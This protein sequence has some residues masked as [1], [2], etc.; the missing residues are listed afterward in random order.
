L[1]EALET[2]ELFSIDGFD[3]LIRGTRHRSRN[4]IIGAES[5][6]NE[7]NRVGIVF[8]NSMSPTRAANG[9]SAV[10]FADSFAE[11]G[12][13]SFRVDLPGF[14]DADGDPSAELHAYINRGG[15]A[16]VAS[17]VISD[18]VRRFHLPGVVIVGHCAGTVSA[19]FTAGA[20]RDCKGL[21][22]MAPYF[23]LPQVAKSQSQQPTHLLPDEHDLP[24]NANLPLLCCLQALSSRGIPIL[25]LNKPERK[26]AEMKAR[27]RTFD[28]LEYVVKLAA[29][30]NRVDLRLAEGSDHSFSNRA[31][32]AAVR[33]HTE[34]WLEANF[35]LADGVGSKVPALH[36][37][38]DPAD[39]IV[40][41]AGGI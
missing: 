23:Y 40:G 29:S 41:I 14:G 37:E 36:Q 32:R 19:I 18:L 3:G 28:Y 34:S 15:Y 25:I 33:H 39:L 6:V 10:Y 38:S 26:S 12:Y 16:P 13:P 8:V 1:K 7:Q 9:D 4:E 20:S 11:C 2:R 5:N 22:L 17:V 31:G 35:P 30:R 24:A 21:I 27:A